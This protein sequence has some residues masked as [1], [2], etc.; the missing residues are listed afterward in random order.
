MLGQFGGQDKAHGVHA[1]VVPAGGYW[2]VGFPIGDFLG[3]HVAAHGGVF[4]RYAGDIV[5]S[6]VGVL[7]LCRD[8]NRRRVSW[9]AA[10]S[11]AIW[12]T[13][14]CRFAELCLGARAGLAALLSAFVL[15]RLR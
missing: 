11:V 5:S 9:T 6:P 10:I 14:A 15:R 13:S 8:R 2:G 12:I 4:I 3:V 1:D 7:Q